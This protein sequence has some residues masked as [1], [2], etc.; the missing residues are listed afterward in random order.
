MKK[1]FLGL[2]LALVLF[3]SVP[4][5][6]DVTFT[7]VQ[8]SD[9]FYISVLVASD[10]GIINGVGN[11]QF[12][13]YGILTVAEAIKLSA[14]IHANYYDVDITPDADSVHW[15]DGYYNYAV[16]NGIIKESDFAKADFDKAIT[17]DRL[18]YIF[19]NT[20]PDSEYIE[21]NDIEVAPE[22]PSTDYL[23]KLFC[24]GIVV[25]NE[26]GFESEKN[27]TRADSVEMVLRMTAHSR[28]RLVFEE[29]QTPPVYT[30]AVE[31]EINRDIIAQ[32]MLTLVND[33]RAKNNM[34][35]LTIHS[36]LMRVA[37]I[38][39]T[40]YSQGS[41]PH[42]LLDGRKD[43]YIAKDLGISIFFETNYGKTA[44]RQSS[45]FHS[46]VMASEGR[47]SNANRALFSE[48]KYYGV[49]SIKGADGNYYWVECF[50]MD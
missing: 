31:N 26:Q 6:A 15:A 3:G 40:E 38:L 37:N 16:E 23:T 20:L 21:I 33:T 12:N 19:A 11:N 4:V 44:L 24:A 29:G 14:C 17:R 27:I 49:A 45:E 8:E 7:D 46:N 50:G 34:Q 9:Y 28:R 13:P 41:Y 42:Y 35:S 18:F 10:K 43:F 32:E 22:K 30:P 5:Y 48:D 47:D 36:D 25:G 2:V 39:A 1:R